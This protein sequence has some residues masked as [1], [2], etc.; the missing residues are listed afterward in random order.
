MVSMGRD[1]FVVN[2]QQD[3]PEVLNYLLDNFCGISVL[4]KVVI[5]SRITCT[6]CL[7]S[8]DRED[9]HMILKLNVA[10]NVN[11][12]FNNYLN[13]EVLLNRECPVCL[14][15]QN[16]SLEKRVVVAGKYV[17]IHLK[18]YLLN[19]GGWV[20]DSVSEQ[21]CFSV[22]LDD[23]VQCRKSY[24]LEASICHSGTLA[25]GHYTAHVLHKRDSQWLLCNDKAVLPI[26]SSE[27]DNEHSYV[28][29]YELS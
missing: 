1:D 12:A 11:S 14:S 4:I 18:R 3:V 20:K 15:K 27:I 7:Q 16:A 10:G 8:D 26:Q 9:I 29:F 21:L 23:E 28:L 19:D 17:I 6:N 5:R 25:A 22:D 2:S 24:H 13:E